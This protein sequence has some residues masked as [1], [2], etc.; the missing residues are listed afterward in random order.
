MRAYYTTDSSTKLLN[1]IVEICFGKFSKD[2]LFLQDNALAH[3][4]LIKLQK[5]GFELVNRQIFI[6]F[7]I[8]LKGKRFSINNKTMSS[9]TCFSITT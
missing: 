2:K 7:Q 3:S 4:S 9:T 1:E 8:V 6:C 5:F